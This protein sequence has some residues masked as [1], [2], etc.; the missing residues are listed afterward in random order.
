MDTYKI[1]EVKESVF[2]DNDREAARVREA[3]KQKGTFLL[4]LM[5]SPGSVVVLPLPGLSHKMATS[6]PP[7]GEVGCSI[8]SLREQAPIRS[9]A[10]TGRRIRCFFAI[11]QLV[12][13]IHNFHKNKRVFSIMEINS[14]KRVKFITN[15]RFYG[16]F[17]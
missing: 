9:S 4:N 13:D 8:S 16:R 3:L 1:I 17:V 6:T 15:P 2:A 10:S 7:D 12:N 14:T 5:S 11:R